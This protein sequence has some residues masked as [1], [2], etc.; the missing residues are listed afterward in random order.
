[1]NKQNLLCIAICGAVVSVIWLGCESL[2]PQH[3]RFY[4]LLAKLMDQLSASRGLLYDTAHSKLIGDCSD[5]LFWQRFLPRAHS[6]IPA[7]TLLTASTITICFLFLDYVTTFK[8]FRAIYQC[9]LISIA[10][11]RVTIDRISPTKHDDRPKSPLSKITVNMAMFGI[12]WMIVAFVLANLE[13]KQWQANTT[14]EITTSELKDI[15]T[16]KKTS[17]EASLYHERKLALSEKGSDLYV[18]VILLEHPERWTPGF[19]FLAAAA[20]GAIGLKAQKR[21]NRKK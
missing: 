9:K 3:D 4:F 12:I 11:N 18:W 8:F 7:L 2:G 21:E 14:F 15:E 13:S 5:A 1:M 19:G 17:A 6:W 16:M 10:A 20:V